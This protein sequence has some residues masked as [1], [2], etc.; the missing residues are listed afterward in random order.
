M[1]NIDKIAKINELIQKEPIFVFTVDIDW[2][3]EDAIKCFLDLFEKYDIPMTIFLTHES[4][5]LREYK[6]SSVHYG[7]HPNFLPDSSQGNSIDAVIDYC[8]KL[9]PN[10]EC[11]RSHRYYDVNDITDKFKKL[12]LKYDSNECTLLEN[13]PPYIHRSGMHRF[14][15]FFEDGA[16]LLHE[17]E[18]NFYKGAEER[19]KTPGIKVLNIHPMHMVVNSPDFWY[20]RRM[21]DKLTRHQWNNL[22][23]SDFHKLAFNGIGI[24]SFILEVVKFIKK[25]N[26]KMF[27]LNQLY[28][29]ITSPQTLK[30]D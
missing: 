18:L 9:V 14:P 5:V 23:Y 27:N 12:G 15:I 24:R 30:Y 3:S 1:S 2:A 28:N 6:K 20:A 7:I 11:F 17:F 10:V 21:K 22:S 26:Y 25:N 16:Y 19:F 8:L 29:L 13:I 4:K